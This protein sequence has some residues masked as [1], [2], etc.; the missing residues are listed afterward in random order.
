M[1]DK[2]FIDTNVLIY[3]IS[4]EIEKSNKI[5]NLF[6]QDL[7]F[8]ISTQVINEFVH[9]CN[10]KKLLPSNDIRRVIEDFLLFF[11]L[12]TLEETTIFSCF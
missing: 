12:T 7:D 3:S 6:R 5:Q 4:T 10:R 9:S 8:V 2:V 11:E 1:N